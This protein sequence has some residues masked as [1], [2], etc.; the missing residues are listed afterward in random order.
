MLLASLTLQ[1]GHATPPAPLQELYQGLHREPTISNLESV[2]HSICDSLTHPY[3]ILDAYDECAI[4][5]QLSVLRLIQHLTGCGVRILIFT[6]PGFGL[7]VRDLLRND[8]GYFVNLEEEKV[9][10][11][12]D[13]QEYLRQKMERGK[14]LH[15]WDPQT[16]QIVMDQLATDS[17]KGYVLSP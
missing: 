10:L 8:T 16:S 9:N 14:Q 12:K 5:L 7:G 6:R 3:I 17:S 13:I 15:Q 1:L 11:E 2:L 4:F